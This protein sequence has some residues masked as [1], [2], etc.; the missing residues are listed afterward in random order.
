MVGDAKQPVH[1]QLENSPGLHP[2][3]RLLAHPHMGEFPDIVHNF[4]GPPIPCNRLKNQFDFCV[5]HH[6]IMDCIVKCL[7]NNEN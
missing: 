7:A 3:E 6:S 5:H 4:F 2:V 1:D